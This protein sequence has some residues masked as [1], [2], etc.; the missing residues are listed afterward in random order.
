MPPPLSPTDPG[1]GAD[2]TDF[3]TSGRQRTNRLSLGVGENPD[4][5]FLSQVKIVVVEGVLRVPTATGHAFTAFTAAGT[6]RPGTSE[7]GV[8]DL[9][10]GLLLTGPAEKNAHVGQTECIAGTHF[11]GDRPVH[12]VSMGGRRVGYHPEHPLSLVVVGRELLSPIGDMTP[13]TIGVESVQWT[14]ERVRV[15]NRTTTDSRPGKNEE[16]ADHINFL[17]SVATKSRRP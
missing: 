7:I 6:G 9:D 10:T 8:R 17:K 13:L 1:T 3:I 4:A 12:L 5:Q 14:V 15:N 2:R 16:T 11:L